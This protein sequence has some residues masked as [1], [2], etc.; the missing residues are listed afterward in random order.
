MYMRD[1]Y[2]YILY[3]YIYV[4][5]YIFLYEKFFISNVKLMLF[6]KK[7][8]KMNNIHVLSKS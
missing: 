7:I 2:I 4:Y 3:I 8:Y 1:I 5:L 6:K